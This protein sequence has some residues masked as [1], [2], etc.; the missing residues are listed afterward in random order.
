MA[1]GNGG[2]RSVAAGQ[3]GV[4]DGSE[5]GDEDEGQEARRQTVHGRT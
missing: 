5:K 3:N 2:R 4:G 1:V